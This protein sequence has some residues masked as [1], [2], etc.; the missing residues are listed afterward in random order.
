MSTLNSNPPIAE[1]R[2]VRGL[3]KLFITHVNFSSALQD[4][5]T[6][7][8]SNSQSQSYGRPYGGAAAYLDAIP[9]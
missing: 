4:A 9:I 6:T 2:V 1:T 7:T 8:A 3:L 5:P